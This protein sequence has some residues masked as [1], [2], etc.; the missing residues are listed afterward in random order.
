MVAT[1]ISYLS[2]VSFGQGW[3]YSA[4]RWRKWPTK[5]GRGLCFGVEFKAL[6]I[7]LREADER[8]NE[9]KSLR[10]SWQSYDDFLREKQMEWTEALLG[11]GNSRREKDMGC[12]CARE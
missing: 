1:G 8:S 6:D 11:D 5:D 12:V 2:T 9:A 7:E 4:T 10:K 3:T